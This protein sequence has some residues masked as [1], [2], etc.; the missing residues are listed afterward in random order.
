[1]SRITVALILIGIAWGIAH[2]SFSWGTVA[3]GAGLSGLG[4]GLGLRRPLY[5][6]A[7]FLS[8]LGISISLYEAAILGMSR[9]LIL[10]PLQ[11]VVV[12]GMLGVLLAGI[13]LNLPRWLLIGLR[14]A[15]AEQRWLAHLHW[16][17]GGICGGVALSQGSRSAWILVAMLGIYVWGV[18]QRWRPVRSKPVTI[19]H[20]RAQLEESLEATAQIEI[21][22]EEEIPSG[23]DRFNA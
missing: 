19:D 6:G 12:L 7:V 3:I 1:M 10:S 15:P 20:M 21:H 8:C 5:R 9:S 18:R 16:G 4:L 11:A 2:V 23:R 14:L 22:G 13:G 17:F